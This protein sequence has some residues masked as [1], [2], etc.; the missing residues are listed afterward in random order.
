MFFQQHAD[1]FG[2]PERLKAFGAVSPWKPHALKHSA[3]PPNYKA[4]YAWRIQTLERLRADSVMLAAAKAYYRTRPAE[5]IMHW[6]DTYNPRKTDNKWMPFV[7]L[8]LIHI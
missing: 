1:L 5:F 7:F 6:M 2:W 4:V 3:W 8:S